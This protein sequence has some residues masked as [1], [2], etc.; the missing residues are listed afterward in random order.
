MPDE[1]GNAV[2]EV[3]EQTAPVESAPVETTEA[4]E[5]P[6]ND[7]GE[8]SQ[9]DVEKAESEPE[10]NAEAPEDKQPRGA[11]KR[12]QQLESEISEL[13][14]KL[15]EETEQVKE[16][17]SPNQEIRDLVA[18]RN[19]LRQRVEQT[20]GEAYRL[21]TEQQLLDQVNPETGEY[22]SPLEAKVTLMEQRQQLEAYN[23]QI[24]EAQLTISTEAEKALR[25]FPMFDSTS[26]KYNPEIAQQ[27]D[28]ILGKSLEFDPRTGQVINSRVSPY[29][30]YKSFHDT[31]MASE[32]RGRVQGQKATEQMLS[33][34]DNAGGAPQ[35]D[36]SFSQM[37]LKEK[38]AYLRRKGHDV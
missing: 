20:N 5:E 18:K 24:A 2:N 22:Y 29:Q 11:E 34:A 26:D 7:T 33:Q 16:D 23:S 21:A 12:K 38:E 28:Q 32:A 8:Y 1:E 9:S 30:L 4:V 31:Y 13:E 27:V 15:P 3:A 35:A 17:T 10:A 36:K 14:Q 37:N 25:D 19:S 6:T